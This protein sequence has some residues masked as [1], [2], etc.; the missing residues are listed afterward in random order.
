M[1]GQATFLEYLCCQPGACGDLGRELDADPC[2]PKCGSVHATREYLVERFGPH[3]D[4]VCILDRAIR[5][6]RKVK[7]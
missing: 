4:F 7:R 5:A 6:W 2:A 3:N 1:N